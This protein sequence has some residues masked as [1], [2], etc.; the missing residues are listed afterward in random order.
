MPAG[1]EPP[2]EP[3][4]DDA[5]AGQLGLEDDAVDPLV[6]MGF[7]DLVEVRLPGAYESDDRLAGGFL[8]DPGDGD[9]ASFLIAFAREAVPLLRTA[10]WIVEFDEDYPFRVIEGEPPDIATELVSELKR[11]SLV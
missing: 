1:E 5:H 4:Q 6:A 11:L 7:V 9:I 8:P 10:G 2:H 3:D